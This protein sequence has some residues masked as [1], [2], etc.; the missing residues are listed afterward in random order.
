MFAIIAAGRRFLS[1]TQSS[2]IARGFG[3]LFPMPW[4]FSWNPA[5]SARSAARLAALKP[6]RLAVGHGK[7]I[8]SP[9][10]QMNRALAIAL[11]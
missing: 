4:L 3:C 11:R 6:S 2:V 9:T 5:L 10:L 1:I 8:V 7:T